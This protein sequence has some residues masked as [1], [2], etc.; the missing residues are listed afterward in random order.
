MRLNRNWLGRRSHN[1][2]FAARLT[3]TRDRR[4]R[5]KVFAKDVKETTNHF[6]KPDPKT[7]LRIEL[8]VATSPATA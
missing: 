2:V 1:F 5:T 8:P 6:E 7:D 4:M 3:W